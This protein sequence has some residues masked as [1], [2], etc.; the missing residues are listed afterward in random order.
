MRVNIILE[1]EE[2]KARNYKTSKN[3]K[4]HS[5][6]LGQKKFCSGCNKHTL[7]KETK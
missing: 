7:H 6:R 1:C 3:K 4:S 2:C 5:E